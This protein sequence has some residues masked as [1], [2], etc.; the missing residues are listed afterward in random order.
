MKK[1]FILIIFLISNN[2]IGQSL[3][4]ANDGNS[5]YR[6]ES[7]EI[8]RYILPA[9]NKTTFISKADLTPAGQSKSLSLR[10]FA[11]SNDQSKILIFANTRKVWRLE[12]RGDYWVLD[13]KT[14]SLKQIGKGSPESSL[15]FA[16]FSPD[17]QR[18]AYV[19]E[20][21][22]Y[23]EHL[24]SGE[25]KPLTQ[26]GN[27]KLIN[28]TFDWAYEEELSCRD[29]FQWSPDGQHIA[30]WQV[31]ANQIRDFYMI[32]NTDS[33]YSR[34]IPVEYPK[35]GQN[36]SPAKIGI[37][38]VSTGITQWLDIP[39]DPKQHYLPRAE[40]HSANTLFVQQLNRKQNESKIY[41][42]ETASGKATLIHTEETG[43]GIDRL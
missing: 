4:W 35:T 11:L 29:G 25:I 24:A 1:L 2:I 8:N 22:V 17:G 12:T 21:N 32:N 33:V 38:N 41:S 7:G 36:P 40:W 14:K 37:V 5:Y 15:M 10:H 13:L 28:G 18:V 19:S 30:F 23:V 39:G 20:Q 9:N 34:I 6:I 27:R 3:R 43:E 26:N 31:D 16:K 42:C